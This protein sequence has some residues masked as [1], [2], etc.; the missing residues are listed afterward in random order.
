MRD[1]KY[2]SSDLNKLNNKFI[3]SHLKVLSDVAN[4]YEYDVKENTPVDSGNLKESISAEQKNSDT[5]I[6]GSDIE[7]APYVELGHLT[8]NGRFVQGSHMFENSFK[9]IEKELDEQVDKLFN[10]LDSLWGE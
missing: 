1:I 10:E 3:E 6:V 2:L 8:K 9:S 4:S 5:F 7:Y